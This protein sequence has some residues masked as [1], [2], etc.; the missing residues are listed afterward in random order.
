MTSMTNVF[1]TKADAGFTEDEITDLG[2]LVHDKRHLGVAEGQPVPGLEKAFKI[3]S[4]VSKKPLFRGPS[5]KLKVPEVGSKFKLPGYSSFSEHKKIAEN[6]A[7][8]H[9]SHVVLELEP[10]AKGFSYMRWMIQGWTE[11]K[12]DDPRLFD[13]QDGQHM[14]DTAEEEAEWIFRLKSVFQVLAVREAGGLT[15]V[16]VKLVK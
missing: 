1:E 4:E 13:S 7:R 6:F 12:T 3:R 15:Y 8:S 2:L 10:G 11:I 9:D 16:S 5:G 14:I